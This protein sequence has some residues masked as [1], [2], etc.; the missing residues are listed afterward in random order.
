MPNVRHRARIAAMQTL[1]E[2]DLTDHPLEPTLERRIADEALSAEGA[3]FARRIARGAWELRHEIDA[4]IEQAAPHW[5][6]YQMPPIEKA[7]L[8]LAIWELLY[9]KHDPAPMKAVINEAVE[10]GKHFGGANSGRF[11]NGV[12]GTVVKT[13]L[14]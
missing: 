9:N 4:I 10:L 3:D 6:L 14:A 5:P 7:I 1:Y 8:R 13:R 12:L 11:I 2:L